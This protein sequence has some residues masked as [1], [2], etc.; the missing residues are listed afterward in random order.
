IVRGDFSECRQRPL[1]ALDCNDPPGAVRQESACETAG[2]GADF[3]DRNACKRPS[4]AG[5]ACREVEIE[6]KILAERFLGAQIVSPDH[7]AQR[8]QIIDRGHAGS[9]SAGA[10]ALAVSRA[11][12]RS[13]AI[14]LAG[15]ARPVPAI[16]KAVPWSGEVRTNGSPR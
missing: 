5:N 8:R 13:A 16:S 15:L 4:G 3:H 6:Q 1:I 14:R 11:A 10:S 9:A 12:S 7:L 2:P